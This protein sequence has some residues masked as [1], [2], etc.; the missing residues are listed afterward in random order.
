MQKLTLIII[1]LLS[2]CNQ[3]FAVDIVSEAVQPNQSIEK[4][5]AAVKDL[6]PGETIEIHYMAPQQGSRAEAMLTSQQRDQLNL[7]KRQKA[8]ALL[9]NVKLTEKYAQ[10]ASKRLP[11]SKVMLEIVRSGRIIEELETQ[12]RAIESAAPKTMMQFKVDSQN[13]S[14]A[15][16]TLTYAR[17]TG[18]S[19]L[20]YEKVQYQGGQAVSR[21]ARLFNFKGN[22]I[23]TVASVGIAAL[24]TAEVQAKPSGELKSQLPNNKGLNN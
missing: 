19:V 10:Y 4:T 12:I 17:A 1:V 22:A 13:I 8:D 21:S 14:R 16:S 3:L 15:V 23:A 5:I 24:L 9:Q 11:T 7:L 20:G 2:V 18:G 6:K